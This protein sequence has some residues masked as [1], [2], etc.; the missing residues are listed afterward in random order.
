MLSSLALLTAP[1]QALHSV[2][3]DGAESRI[4]RSGQCAQH[5]LENSSRSILTLV[6]VQGAGSVNRETAGALLRGAL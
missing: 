5:S 4:L 6:T 2:Q 1:T 3:W